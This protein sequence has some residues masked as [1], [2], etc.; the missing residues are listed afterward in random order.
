MSRHEATL[1]A[2]REA[3]A[4]HAHQATVADLS[5]RAVGAVGRRGERDRSDL[6]AL[7][8]ALPSADAL[9]AAK[10]QRLDLADV[11]VGEERPPGA[12]TVRVGGDPCGAVR[13]QTGHH[14]RGRHQHGCAW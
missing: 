9:L 5:A 6:R 2:V 11:P 13:P 10:R 3:A 1:R 8:R 14:D 7:A 12:E 4:R